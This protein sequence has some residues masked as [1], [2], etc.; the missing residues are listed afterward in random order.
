M[1]SNN[2]IPKF[3]TPALVTTMVAGVFAA[4]ASGDDEQAHSLEDQLHL[5]ILRGIAGKDG[6]SILNFQECA[7]IALRT[8]ELT[9]VR[10]C[11]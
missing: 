6:Y 10:H 11:A 4:A 8:Q 2:E 9:F 7:R 3:L 5:A 1:S